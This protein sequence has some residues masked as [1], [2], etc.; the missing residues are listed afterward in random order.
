MLNWIFWNRTVWTSNSR[1]G[2]LW[3]AALFCVTVITPLVADPHYISFLK[4][5]LFM[6]S[7]SFSGFWQGCYT[8]LYGHIKYN[9]EGERKRTNE[10]TQPWVRLK[11][12]EREFCDTLHSP[13][14]CRLLRMCILRKTSTKATRNANS[15][16]TVFPHCLLLLT[17]PPLDCYLTLTGLFCSPL[18]TASLYLPS[19]TASSLVPSSPPPLS[20]LWEISGSSPLFGF[21]TK[22]KRSSNRHTHTHTQHI[23]HIVSHNPQEPLKN[24]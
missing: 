23:G 22:T 13:C 17:V 2:K 18:S 24:K 4:P 16:L 12:Q 10:Q 8:F 9:W 14:I 20:V 5:I 15:S 7:D 11:E 1:V 6:A 21:H 19:S 3:P